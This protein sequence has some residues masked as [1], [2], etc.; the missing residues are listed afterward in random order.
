MSDIYSQPA[1]KPEDQLNEIKQQLEAKKKHYEKFKFK[2]SHSGEILHE[3]RQS[4]QN[5]LNKLNS[6]DTRDVA[7]RE[8]KQLIDRNVS[9]EALKI[10]LGTLG[11]LKKVKS[12][13]ARE[14]EVQ[15][16]GFIAQV[17]GER[18][19]EDGASLKNISKILEIIR[20]FYGD[21]S[22]PVH[23]AAAAA[24][25]EVYT[26]SMLKDNPELIFGLFFDP[27]EIAMTSGVNVKAQQAAS[28]SIFK[29]MQVLIQEENLEVIMGCYPRIVSLYIRLRTDFPDLISTL[30]VLI[31]SQGVQQ[32]LPEIHPILKKTMQYLNTS[33]VGTHLYKIEACKLLSCLARQL[34]GIADVV[35]DPFHNEVIFLLQEVKVDKLQAVQ[36]A[37]RQALH[38]W[39]MLETIQKAIEAKKM[40]EQSVASDDIVKS[41]GA[42]KRDI[43]PGRMAPNNFKAIRELA[44]RNKQNTDKWGLAKPKFLEKKSGNYSN[45]PHQSREGMHKSREEPFYPN[46][47]MP[48]EGVNKHVMEVIQKKS[49]E[50]RA[51]GEVYYEED[52]SPQR[53]IFIKHSPQRQDLGLLSQ[54]IQ[55]TFKSM[56]ATMDKGFKSIGSRL[57]KLDSR[58]DN[59]YDKLQTLNT[60]SSVPSFIHPPPAET[61]ANFTQTQNNVEIQAFMSQTNLSSPGSVGSV[62]GLDVLSQAWIEVLQWV[63]EGNMEEAYRRVLGTGDDIYLLRLMHKTG[64]CFKHMSADTS[65]AVLQRLG[66]ILNS[67]FLENL[68]MNWI[69]QAIRERV[70]QRMQDDDKES[71]FEAMQRY[72]ALPGEEGE[73]AGEIL[74]E[75]NY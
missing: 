31:E 68:G 53:E 27:L 61:T 58:M 44:K 11:E 13:G 67:N 17:F 15:I 37:A 35:I 18:M 38:D 41:H 21:L 45:S 19:L 42:N 71:I 60:K 22:R 6:L 3:L 26:H 57:Q 28:L 64:V 39:K 62:R 65:K 54:K 24:F 43:S 52:S 47:V 32:I 63:S 48:K 36:N 49:Q 2:H 34:Q 9:S 70:F 20:E 8:L 25:C 72:S 14:Q 40:E 55:G 66:M 33:G 50:S 10:Y 46:I 30:G 16:I 29:W 4:F 69:S 73:L 5:S 1:L 59:A 51:R 23:E 56:E 7:V 74:K 75:I 12:P